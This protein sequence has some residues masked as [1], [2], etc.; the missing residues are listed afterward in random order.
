MKRLLSLLF[1]LLVAAS[2]AA[3]GDDDLSSKPFDMD[4]F[5]N[6]IASDPPQG[7]VMVEF[8]HYEGNDGVFLDTTRE[9]TLS[10][11]PVVIG[12]DN[13]TIQTGG[14]ESSIQTRR[15]GDVIYFRSDILGQES[16]RM[17]MAASDLARGELSVISNLEIDDIFG[18]EINGSRGWTPAGEAPC[19]VGLMFHSGTRQ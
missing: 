8:S 17:K 5:F 15:I 11:G 18:A 10:I 3:C 12:E 7:I 1:A 13:Y 14:G 2:L 6:D 9:S 4:R 19:R 16:G